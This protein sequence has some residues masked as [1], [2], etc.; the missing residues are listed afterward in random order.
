VTLEDTD[1]QA[2]IGATLEFVFEDGSRGIGGV[3][4][5]GV[6]DL[7]VPGS[8]ESVVKLTASLPW[9]TTC[10]IGKGEEEAET[11][12][13]FGIAS[14][15]AETFPFVTRDAELVVTRSLVLPKIESINY[16]IGLEGTFPDVAMLS[17]NV[18]AKNDLV[19]HLEDKVWFLFLI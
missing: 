17:S 1:N 4:E 14:L 5:R 2:A 15:S 9:Q 13:V 16:Q 12:T 19:I 18:M 8:S 11:K 7:I 6:Y 3:D 10:G